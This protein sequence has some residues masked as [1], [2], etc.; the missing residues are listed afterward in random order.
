MMTKLMDRAGMGMTGMGVPSMGPGM[1]GAVPSMPAGMNP[2]MVP[3][4]SMTMERCRGGMKITCCCDDATSAGMLRNLCTVLAG[5]LCSCALMM[6]GMVVCGCNLTMGMCRCE[7]TEDGC[8]LT[9]TSGDA[10]CCAMIE[11]CCDC[12]AALMKTGC[13]CCLMMGGTPVCCGC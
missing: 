7:M 3:R 1:M 12:M 13:T 10:D 4:C 5:G 8:T 9:C 2:M 6:N 11:A